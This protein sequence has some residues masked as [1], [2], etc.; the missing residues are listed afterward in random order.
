MVDIVHVCVYYHNWYTSWRKEKALR[1]DCCPTP[2]AWAQD[3]PP[4]HSSEPC[5]PGPSF[6]I[7]KMRGLDCV[8]SKALLLCYDVSLVRAGQCLLIAGAGRPV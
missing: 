4:C 7:C 3:S 6:L 8:V 5:T 2:T 1:Q